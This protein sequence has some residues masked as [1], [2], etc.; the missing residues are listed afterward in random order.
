MTRSYPRIALGLF[1]AVLPVAVLHA[2]PLTSADTNNDGKIS[3]DEAMAAQN[4]AFKHL[5]SNSDGQLSRDEFDAGQ[6]KLP[7]DASAA[8]KQRRH[9]IVN[10]WFDR[11]DANGDGHITASEYRQAVAPYFDRLD[12]NHDG[13]ISRQE[14]RD[15]FEKAHKA[16]QQLDS[17]Q[18]S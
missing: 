2:A 13:S 5:D 12:T 1:V 4:S 10:Q 11:I 16:Q 3:H 17:K 18:G 7:K 9:K 8:D 15:T 14:L 6:P